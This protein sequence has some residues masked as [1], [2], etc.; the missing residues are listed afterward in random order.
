MQG[1]EVGAIDIE[2]WTALCDDV[3]SETYSSR[4]RSEA[5]SEEANNPSVSEHET[6]ICTVLH[7][8][9]KDR[10]AGHLDLAADPCQEGMQLCSIEPNKQR[11]FS[12]FSLCCLVCLVAYIWLVVQFWK[13][14]AADVQ[15]D[16]EISRLFSG[17]G[18][19][20]AMIMQ[21]NEA[22]KQSKLQI[23]ELKQSNAALN[24]SQV[25]LLDQKEDAIK[26]MYDQSEVLH[27]QADVI[28]MLHDQSSPAKRT[29]VAA[30][31]R[32]RGM[33]RMEAQKTRHSIFA[34]LP[35]T[36]AT[37]RAKCEE[38]SCSCRF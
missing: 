19:L 24:Q 38:P 32:G 11:I 36:L 20:E 31:F 29:A 21:Q 10:M 12:T 16:A 4:S 14:K 25:E 13:L 2:G 3:S 26:T 33:V 5:E 6:A 9:D 22:L 37:S 35:R 34:E 15:K 7:L 28:K 30:F 18:R 23:E 27:R 17:Q 8:P 1:S